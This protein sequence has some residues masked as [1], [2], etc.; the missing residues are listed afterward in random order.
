VF[1]FSPRAYDRGLG[2]IAVSIL[3]NGSYMNG[4][5]INPEWAREDDSWKSSVGNS[6]SRLMSSH[7]L[8]PEINA[9]VDAIETKSQR[10]PKTRRPVAKVIENHLNS[11]F[12][13]WEN[14][15]SSER[16]LFYYES[17]FNN[18]PRHPVVLG[19]IQHKRSV[20]QNTP[21]SMR[22]VEGTT[23]FSGR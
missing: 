12:E 20:F 16:D 11:E 14:K 10:Q 19:D 2:P 8:D 18:E 7:R 9:I 1:P 4:I 21:Q 3:R 15:A 22:E 23:R 13:R 6:G 5:R 17:S